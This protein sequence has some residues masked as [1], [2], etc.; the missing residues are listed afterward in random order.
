MI[1]P[2]DDSADPDFVVGAVLAQTEDLDHETTVR[3]L[4][5]ALLKSVEA[6]AGSET[7]R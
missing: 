1:P 2:E 6:L 7:L 5:T 3:V 4:R